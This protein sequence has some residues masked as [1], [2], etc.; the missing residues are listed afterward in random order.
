MTLLPERS[1]GSNFEIESLLSIAPKV[2]CRAGQLKAYGRLERKRQRIWYSALGSI[3]RYRGYLVNV[4]TVFLLQLSKN[5]FGRTR[6]GLRGKI[7]RQG[8]L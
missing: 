5:P 1:E 8:L 2:I 4:G 3:F 6:T 7:P